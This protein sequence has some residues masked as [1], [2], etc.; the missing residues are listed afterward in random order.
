MTAART[1]V[2]STAYDLKHA[3]ARLSAFLRSIGHMPLMHEESS[4]GVAPDRHSHD[5]CLDQVDSAD[6]LVLIIGGRRGGTY[7][8]SERSI[9]SEEHRRA[10][11]RGIPVLIFVQ[12]DVDAALRLYRANPTADFSAV[13]DDVRIFDFIDLVR[14]EATNNWTWTFETVEDIVE[15]LLGQF[16]FFHQLFS[17]AHVA[18]TRP[19]KKKNADSDGKVPRVLPFPRD[20]RASLPGCEAP[21]DRN[22]FVEGLGV[23]H[24][25]LKKMVASKVQG[26]DEKVK[27][28]WVFGRYGRD[29]PLGHRSVLQMNEANFKQYA[30]GGYRGERVFEQMRDFGVA[31]SYDFEDSPATVQIAMD[32]KDGSAALYALRKYVADLVERHGEDGLELFRRFDLTMYR[33]E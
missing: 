2:S 26:Y 3:R 16:S 11:R 18:K 31:G 27:L 19:S 22:V 7:V 8:G 29:V 20:L 10:Q 13:V 28:L 30:W 12:K 33:E 24:A 4:F 14:S 23:L 9:T 17:K 32:G 15:V 21:D 5:A 1:F 6:F 25:S